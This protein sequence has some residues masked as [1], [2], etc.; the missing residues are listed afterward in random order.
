M[1]KLKTLATGVSIELIDSKILEI[2]GP[3]DKVDHVVKVIERL[4]SMA[5]AK[6]GYVLTI[7]F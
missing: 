7:S 1:A 6:S 4:V 5:Q 2:D 3:K